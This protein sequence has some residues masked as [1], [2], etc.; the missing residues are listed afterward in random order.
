MPA[1]RVYFLLNAA[2]Q[3]RTVEAC[4]RTVPLSFGILP[5]GVY[6]LRAKST[7][8]SGGMGHWNTDRERFRRSDAGLRSKE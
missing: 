7:N 4:G 1:V 2:Q 8:R 3:E 5:T 6:G